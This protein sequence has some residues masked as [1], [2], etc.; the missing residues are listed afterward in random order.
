MRK[1]PLPTAIVILVTVTGV[2]IA[3]AWLL[4]C[5]QRD[6][7]RMMAEYNLTAIAD[8]KANQLAMWRNERLADANV[9]YKNDAFTALVRRCADHP[10]DLSGQKELQTWLDH[11]RMSSSYDRVLLFDAVGKKWLC[12]DDMTTPPSAT[13]YHNVQEALRPGATDVHGLLSHNS[14]PAD[15]LAALRAH[16]RRAGRQQA[17]RRAHAE[18]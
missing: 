18:C 14:H 8:L 4:F 7:C 10:Q 12:F 13:T 2:I 11:F 1:F 16:S 15:S 5:N 17:A 6:S 9:F 3:V